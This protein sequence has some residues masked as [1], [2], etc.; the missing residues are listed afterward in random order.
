M[1]AALATL[2]LLA[3]DPDGGGLL[4][5]GAVS[6]GAGYDGGAAL[7]PGGLGSTAGTLAAALGASLEL[8]ESGSLYAGAR[9]DGLWYAEAP[10]LSR[11]EVAAEASA[12][13]EL[14]RLALT[15]IPSG[16]WA[17]NGDPS[18][19]GPVWAGRLV[20]R[21][22]AAEA[23]SLRAS[24]AHA[25]RGA[26]E[27]VYATEWDRVTAGVELR[28]GRGTFLSLWAGTGWGEE[29]FYVPVEV[30]VSAA[31]GAGPGGPGPG[32][33]GGLAGSAPVKAPATEGRL[34][35]DLELG[36]GGGFH[37]DLGAA[38]R[39]VAPEGADPTTA[40]SA[41]GQIGWRLR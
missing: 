9:A 11:T 30:A 8:G 28:L 27:P 26:A 5:E 15:A 19:D 41:L 10:D 1:L 17:W 23:L 16:G 21:L 32:P 37:L 14:G 36:L 35:V 4:L 2:A 34:G 29:V 3:G 25:S 31:M 38:V 22:R 7:G 40:A 6:G 18:R 24:Y 39:R 33:G 12:G 13:L 20:L